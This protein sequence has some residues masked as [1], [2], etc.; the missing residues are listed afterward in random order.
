MW[1]V[2]L[3]PTGSLTGDFDYPK[4]RKNVYLAPH[5]FKY[6]IISN[7]YLI[8]KGVTDKDSVLVIILANNLIYM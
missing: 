4:N 5:F 8:M 6:L 7:D 2:G 3:T 1:K